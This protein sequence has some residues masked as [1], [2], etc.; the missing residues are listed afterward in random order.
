LREALKALEIM[1][2]I[3]TRLGEGTFV[4]HRSEFFSRPLLWAIT[5]S[6]KADAHELVEARKLM[7]VEMAGFAAERATAEDLQTIGKY[8]EEMEASLD[9]ATRF[10][11]ADLNFHMAVAQ[12]AHNRILLNA[13]NLIRNLLRQWIA[14][15][16][17]LEGVAPTALKQ[18]KKI[19]AAIAK[20]NAAGARSAMQAHLEAMAALLQDGSGDTAERGQQDV[21]RMQPQ[22]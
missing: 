9:N 12:A 20:R 22:A 8:L 15:S 21:P 5:G 1:G 19:E 6:A 3:E 18:H 2:M 10:L 4:C 17:K 14:Q 16:L 13:L 11:E 7:E